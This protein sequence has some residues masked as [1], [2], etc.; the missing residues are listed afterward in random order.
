MGRG[1]LVGSV[2]VFAATFARVMPAQSGS[3]TPVIR[4]TTRLVQV[5]VIVQDKNRRP[6]ADLKREDFILLEEGKPQPIRFFSVTSSEA[7]PQQVN[8]EP[9]V[10]T[11]RLEA[12]GDVPTSVTVILFDTLN[13]A[14]THRV[15]AKEGVV[16]ILRKLRPNDRVALYA[17][18]RDL[19]VLHDFTSEAEPLLRALEGHGGPSER[20][21]AASEGDSG[22]AG[23]QAVDEVLNEMAQD[24]Q[25]FMFEQRAL[26]SL[27][28][29]EAI[30]RR[31]AQVPGRK[32]VIWVSGAFP[33]ID[34]LTA[35]RAT[36]MFWYTQRAA[37]LLNN[38][39]ISVY[40]VG[41]HGLTAP[42]EAPRPGPTVNV[43][44][45][46]IR[47]GPII[48][49]TPPPSDTM[50]LLADSTGGRAFVRTNDVEAAIHRI[51]D[52]S[53]VTYT[54]S[55]Y[56]SHDKWNG[57]YRKLSVKVKRPGADVRHRKGYFAVP[58]RALTSANRDVI[59]R[60]ALA[61]PLDAT[62][63]SINAKVLAQGN[64]S[65]AVMVR[66]NPNELQF[67][68]GEGQHRGVADIMLVMRG[69]G[70]QVLWSENYASDLKLDEKAFAE[71]MRQGIVL[72]REVKP[73]EGAFELRI[74]AGDARTGA[75]GSVT[76]PLSKIPPAPAAETR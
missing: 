41:A 76:V 22:G 15:Q 44:G 48:N 28:A 42:W 71:L 27:E 33:I 62:G 54:L 39:N 53:R 40:P 69:A 49:T 36:P 73:V 30:A 18:G 25:V 57:A 51:L 21:L 46:D 45:R 9:G 16:K 26:R 58:E 19:R 11:N 74:L 60:E 47:P 7:L 29:F 5:S 68:T 52:D 17:L 38:A 24:T 31:L 37:W 2:L 20:E 23:L 35:Q 4:T 61:S 8:A 64:G 59:L 65:Y 10:F 66:L 70:G 12:Q 1:F 72:R 67:E 56:P 3:D 14:F 6:V 55:Y 13:T 32:N 50:H 75:L 34:H 63:L 43:S